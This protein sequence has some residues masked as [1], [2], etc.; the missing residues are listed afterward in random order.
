MACND[1]TFSPITPVYTNAKYVLNPNCSDAAYSPIYVPAEGLIPGRTTELIA[2]QDILVEDFSDADVDRFRVSYSAYVPVELNFSTSAY[3]LSALQS[4]PI[5]KGKIV[6]EIRSTW[7]INKNVSTQSIDEDGNVTALNAADRNKTTTGLTITDNA[8][9][10]LTVDD[11]SGRTGGIAVDSD[12]IVFGN[13]MIWGD[14]TNMIG[15]PASSISTLIANLASKNTQIKTSRANSVYATGL[16]NRHF[17]IIYPAAWGEGTFYK[18][19]FYGGFQR[20]KNDGGTLVVTVAGSETPISWTNEE[21]YSENYYVYQ[22]L[23]DNPEDAVEPIVI[24]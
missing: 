13:Y 10:E 23:Y 16:T 4:E 19:P 14:Y 12:T 6:D 3:I 15:Q 21:G 9:I 20:L 22:S 24:S 17:F 11:A 5:L 18:E 8:T 7:T 1:E 2:G